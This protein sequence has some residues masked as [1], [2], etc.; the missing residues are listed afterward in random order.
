MIM[1]NLARYD[2]DSQKIAISGPVT[3]I[4]PTAIGSKRATCWSI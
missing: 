4:G 1:A 2:L 3:V